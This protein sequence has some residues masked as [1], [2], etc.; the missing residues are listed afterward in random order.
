MRTK[1][2]DW[3]SESVRASYADKFSRQWKHMG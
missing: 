1:S 2:Q 3:E